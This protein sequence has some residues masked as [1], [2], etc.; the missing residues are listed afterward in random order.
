MRGGVLQVA[1]RCC[2]QIVE[3]VPGVLAVYLFGSAATDQMHEE[4]DIDLALY[5]EEPVVRLRL[6]D[7]A[8]QLA[9][10]AG[11]DVDVVD[12]RTGTA[13]SVMRMQVLSTGK[14]LFCAD[15]GRCGQFE[16]LVFPIM[17]A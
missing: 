1:E 14:R 7:V 5:A 16:D 13:S 12:L 11:R 17:R 6:W 9:T 15:E 8:Q 4:S 3:T 10:I 2:D